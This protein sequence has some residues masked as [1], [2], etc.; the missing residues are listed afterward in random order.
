M[1]LLLGFF[2]GFEQALLNFHAHRRRFIGTNEGNLAGSMRSRC[3]TSMSLSSLIDAAFTPA[4]VQW[5][6]TASA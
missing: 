2:K 1:P 3:P 4:T 5:S 6:T